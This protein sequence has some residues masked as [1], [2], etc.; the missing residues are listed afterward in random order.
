MATP[1]PFSTPRTTSEKPSPARAGA[2]TRGPGRQIFWI[3]LG[4]VAIFFGVR[5]LPTGTNLSHVDFQVQG[6]SIEFCDPTN[7]QFI[8]VVAVRS[9]V[10]MDLVFVSPHPT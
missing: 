5:P 2:P 6:S 3:T 4:G 7:P 1:A 10:T 8:P 9:P